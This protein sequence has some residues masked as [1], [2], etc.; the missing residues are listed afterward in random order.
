[1]GT[2]ANMVPY[3]KLS[4]ESKTKCAMHLAARHLEKKGYPRQEA[5]R[6]AKEMY[7]WPT[8]SQT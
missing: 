5:L 2:P 6:R 1:M 3:N 8:S 4:A 7:I